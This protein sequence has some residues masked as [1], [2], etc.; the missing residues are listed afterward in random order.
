MPYRRLYWSVEPDVQNDLISASMK[1]N[2]FD[3]IMQFLHLAKNI[4]MNSDRYY[5]VKPLFKAVNET[6]KQFPLQ[7]NISIDESM[8]SRALNSSLEKSLSGLG[9]NSFP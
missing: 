1:R 9:S 4:K 5:K 3:E 7:P 8:V 6:F 2:R